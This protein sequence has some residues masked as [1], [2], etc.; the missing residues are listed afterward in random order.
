MDKGANSKNLIF[1][2]VQNAV[3]FVYLIGFPPKNLQFSKKDEI[4]F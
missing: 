2:K 1:Y 3:M 4:F